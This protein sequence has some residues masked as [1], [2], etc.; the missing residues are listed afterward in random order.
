VITNEN[1][2]KEEEF[3]GRIKRFGT[4]QKFINERIDEKN[5][6]KTKL[7]EEFRY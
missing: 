4:I 7:L 2:I 5:K 3:K 1:T 6:I